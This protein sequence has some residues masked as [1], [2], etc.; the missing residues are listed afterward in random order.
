MRLCGRRMHPGGALMPMCGL[1]DEEGPH[2]KFEKENNPYRKDVYPRD[3][4]SL[5]NR[6]QEVKR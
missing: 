4:T 6:Y 2:D 1:G 5:Y 3:I